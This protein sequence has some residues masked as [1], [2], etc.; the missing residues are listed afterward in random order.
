MIIT[1]LRDKYRIGSNKGITYL[2]IPEFLI[3]FNMIIDWDLCTFPPKIVDGN[4]VEG[5]QDRE[6][7]GNPPELKVGDMFIIDGGQVCTF[8]SQDR[9]ILCISESGAGALQRIYDEKISIEFD[10]RM[11]Y[12]GTKVEFKNIKPDQIPE[13]LDVY[14]APYPLMI[15]FKERFLM[16]RPEWT[17]FLEVTMETDNFFI[18]IHLYICDWKILFDPECCVPE[19]AYE[20]ISKELL[21]YFYNSYPILKVEDE[22]TVPSESTGD[23]E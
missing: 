8:D 20:D 14:N 11:N 17:P 21:A 9:L 18:P 5:E 16:G 2:D 19:E 7:L 13:N 23:S 3:K 15:L 4:I 22:N 6:I 12:I 10:Y 1:V